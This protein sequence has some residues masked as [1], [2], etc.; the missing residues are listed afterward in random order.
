MPDETEDRHFS[1]GQDPADRGGRRSRTRAKGCAQGSRPDRRRSSDAFGRA[2]AARAP[3]ELEQVQQ[4]CVSGFASGL[5]RNKEIKPSRR[6]AALRSEGRAHSW[7]PAGN[8]LTI[9]PS[10]LRPKL[11]RNSTEIRQTCLSSGAT[12]LRS[13]TTV[14]RPDKVRNASLYTPP[15]CGRAFRLLT[16]QQS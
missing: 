9:R 6:P 12:T 14:P 10:R 11:G 2:P 7:H 1:A 15:Y 13:G 8:V 5:R 16:L 3:A 4:T